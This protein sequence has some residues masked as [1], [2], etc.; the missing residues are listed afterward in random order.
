MNVFGALISPMRTEP[1]VG[2]TAG[3]DGAA[4]DAAGVIRAKQALPLTPETAEA[5]IDR[6]G[7]GR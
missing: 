2:T 1:P 7:L 4:V 3:V 5:L 6:A